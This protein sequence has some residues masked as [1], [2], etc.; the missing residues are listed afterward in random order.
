MTVIFWETNLNI[1]FC[2]RKTRFF[3]RKL[4]KIGLNCDRNIGPGFSVFRKTQTRGWCVSTRKQ[5]F[6]IAQCKKFFYLHCTYIGLSFVTRG[7]EP[8]FA[9]PL[10]WR[11]ERAHSHLGDNLAP[12]RKIH[13]WGRTRFVKT[14][15]TWQNFAG[16]WV[17]NQGRVFAQSAIVF[18]W[19]KFIELAQM[20]GLPL[21]NKKWVWR[22][23]GRHFRRFFHK[24]ICSPCSRCFSSL[25]ADDFFSGD[26]E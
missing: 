4:A 5:S 26:E 22:H 14:G 24:L 12:R 8:L 11:E 18:F 9:P 21:P 15:F 10:F 1:I 25:A 23:L 16:S 13:P 3:R 6:D 17:R 20:S 7:E 2:K 19:A